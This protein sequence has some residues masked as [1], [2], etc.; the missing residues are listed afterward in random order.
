VVKRTFKLMAELSAVIVAGVT[1]LVVVAAVRLSEGPIALDFLTPH[2]ERGLNTEAGDFKVS[3]GGTVLAWSK[4]D[5]DLDIVLRD[6]RVTNKEGAGQAAVPQLAIGLSIRALLIGEF[7]P[8][9]FELFGPTLKLVRGSDGTIAFG[10][11]GAGEAADASLLGGGITA[12]VVESLLDTPPAGHPLHYLRSVRFTRTT[13]EF[14]DQANSFRLTSPDSEL[15]LVRERGGIA[16]SARLHPTVEGESAPVDISGGY[17]AARKKIQ[18]TAR[19]RNLALGRMAK[20]GA[21]LAPLAA[22]QFPA[23]GEIGV[24]MDPGGRVDD[25]TLEATAGPGEL[26]LADLYPRPVPVRAVRIKAS[27]GDGFRRFHLDHLTMDLAGARIGLSGQGVRDGRRTTIELRATARDLTVARLKSLWPTGAADGAREWVVE[28]LEDGTIGRVEAKL[29]LAIDAGEGGKP[30][31]VDVTALDGGFE[32]SGVKVHYLKPLPAIEALAGRARLTK[33]AFVIEEAHG[34]TRGLTLEE[35][36]V[37]ITGLDQDKAENQK[38]KVEAVARGPLPAALA[39]LAHPRLDLLKGFGIRP[40]SVTGDMATRL[41]VTLPL[42]KTVTID[43]VEVAAASN[44]KGVD[45]P[46]VALDSDL[47]DGDLTLQVDKRGMDVSGAIRLGGVPVKLA[48]TENFYPGA[49]FRGRYQV[50]GLIDDAGRKTLGLDSLPHVT[51]PLGFDVV[52]TRFDKKRTG[53]SGNLDVRQATLNFSEIEWAKKPGV[54]G[55]AR[56]SLNLIDD[57]PRHIPSLVIKA[58]DLEAEGS[59]RLKPD[60]ITVER[61]QFAKLVFGESDIKVT[62]QA[63]PDG[64]LDLSVR[65]AAIDVRPFLESRRKQGVKRPLSITVE[66]DEARVGPGPAIGAV[67]GSLSRGTGDWRNMSITGEVGKDREPV[68]VSIKPIEGGRELIITS[69]DAGATLNSF[70]ITGDMVGGQ[71]TIKGKYDDAKPGAPLSGTFLVQKFQMVRAPL[72]A[73]LLGV[74]SLDGIVSTLS[75]KGIAFDEAVVPF[76]KTGDDLRIK[77]ARAYGSALGFTAKG[78]MDLEQ[79]RLDISGTV[80]PAYTI[81]KILGWI[82]LLGDIL[83]GEKG[84]GVFAATY[85]MYGP[86]SEPKVSTNP[87]ATFAP[88]MLRELLGIFDSKSKKPPSEQTQTVPAPTT[89]TR[90]PAEAAQ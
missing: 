50:S 56:F 89:K 40:S 73:K 60:G 80:V 87:L 30:D 36:R 10:D 23:D 20:L 27:T 58:G 16:V 11:T 7:R 78:W 61:F 5:R 49:R 66:I 24:V 33:D 84:S 85:R 55:S 57:K 43:M 64:G 41:T 74:L 45:I 8:T 31:S 37:N 59:V 88:G 54:G 75:G 90:P 63:R 19:F 81:N 18:I 70:D 35:G 42:L 82:P 71:L 83:V 12:K 79:D 44:V 4:A 22:I 86:F 39:L 48:W 21:A 72:M 2:I 76:I 14:E 15:V 38:L 46:K 29:A 25:L 34:R 62:G 47:T 69:N 26:T 32:F 51:G 52:I 65:G 1:V 6:V 68:L 53:I 77:D 28:N 13:L 67:K 9:R 3:L 17:N